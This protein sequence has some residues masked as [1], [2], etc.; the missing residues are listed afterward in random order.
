MVI[1]SLLKSLAKIGHRCCL[2]DG[3]SNR[4]LSIGYFVFVGCVDERN[5]SRV[6]DA[7]T[8]GSVIPAPKR[9]NDRAQQPDYNRTIDYD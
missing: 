5:L 1:N 7:L 4:V 2:V 6:S 3:I 9:D 8:I